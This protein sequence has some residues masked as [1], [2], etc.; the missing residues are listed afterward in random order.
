ML[1]Y[2]LIRKPGLIKY[3][4]NHA[5]WWISGSLDENACFSLLS[6]AFRQVIGVL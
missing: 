1:V 6:Q 3:V 5:I 2:K 4:A